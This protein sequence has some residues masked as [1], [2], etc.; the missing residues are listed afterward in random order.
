M[1]SILVD[2]WLSIDYLLNLSSINNNIEQQSEFLHTYSNESKALYVVNED[3]VL[4]LLK[5]F[6]NKL[7]DVWGMSCEVFEWEALASIRRLLP[8]WICEIDVCRIRCGFVQ[9]RAV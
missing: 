6:K 8:G 5:F 2:G 7:G 1:V 9:L 4:S 3:I